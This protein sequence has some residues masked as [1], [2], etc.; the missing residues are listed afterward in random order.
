MSII[1]VL[2]ALVT[3]ASICSFFGSVDAGPRLTEDERVQQWHQRGNIW[4]P[5]WQQE[6]QGYLDLHAAREE[7]LMLIPGGDERWENWMVIGKVASGS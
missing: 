4:P 5:N 7:E 2:Q 1:G 6:H 3:F